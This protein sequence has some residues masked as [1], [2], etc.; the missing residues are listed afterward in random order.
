[1]LAHLAGAG[2]SRQSIP[3][4]FTAQAQRHEGCSGLLLVPVC[5]LNCCVVLSHLALRLL[6]A[7]GRLCSLLQVKTAVYFPEYIGVFVFVHNWS[8]KGLSCY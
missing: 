8:Y 7:S 4:A 6:Q 2:F 5:L 3:K 1:M